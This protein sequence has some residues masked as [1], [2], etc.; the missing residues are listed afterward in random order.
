MLYDAANICREVHFPE[1]TE[2]HRDGRICGEWLE[3]LEQGQLSD[4][5][6]G[7]TMR[8]V[9]AN[10]LMYLGRYDTGQ[11]VRLQKSLSLTQPPR[12]HIKEISISIWPPRFTL[13]F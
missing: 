3:N 7:L 6:R 2:L 13:K 12:R 9:A 11:L 4:A 1:A 10:Q 5:Q 8:M